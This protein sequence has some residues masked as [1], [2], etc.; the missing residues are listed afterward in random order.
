MNK[1]KLMLVVA[2]FSACLLMLTGCQKKEMSQAQMSKI[3]KTANENYNKGELTEKTAA[4]VMGIPT[5][6]TISGKFQDKPLKLSAEMTTKAVGK[7]Q[8]DQIYVEN[9]KSYTKH[10]GKWKEAKFSNVDAQDYQKPMKMVNQKEFNKNMKFNQTKN[11]DIEA[12]IELN[13]KQRQKYL[14]TYVKKEVGNDAFTKAYLKDTKIKRVEI[15]ELVDPK[16]KKVKHV[17]GKIAVSSMLLDYDENINLNS[18]K[19][20]AKIARPS[21][22]K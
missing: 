18:I 12:K 13:K 16:T 20:S 10:N 15:S 7:K 6:T 21:D 2:V 17:D 3:V 8:R 9:G 22:L 5:H 1:H 14:N 11:G 19:D 4:T